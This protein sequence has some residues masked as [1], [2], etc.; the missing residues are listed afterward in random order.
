[1]Q[2]S[3]WLMLKVVGL[4][5]VLSYLIKYV[6]PYLGIP[7]TSAVALFIILLPC[8]IMLGLLGWRSL[9]TN[10]YNANR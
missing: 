6:V 5:A 8:L 2:H 10:G 7:A 3:V 4:S 1:M 9:Q